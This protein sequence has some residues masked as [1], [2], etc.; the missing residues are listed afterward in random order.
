MGPGPAFSEG[1]DVLLTAA[2]GV[3]W[4][5][6]GCRGH[7]GGSGEQTL[8]DPRLSTEFFKCHEGKR[9]TSACH[10]VVLV[11]QMSKRRITQ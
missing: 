6:P 1:L 7:R 4:G 8:N 3:T 10:P 11:F 2:F 5:F 9:S